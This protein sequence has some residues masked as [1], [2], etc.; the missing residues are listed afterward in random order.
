MYLEGESYLDFALKSIKNTFEFV[1]NLLNGYLIANIILQTLFIHIPFLVVLV[2]GDMLAGEAT[3]GTYRLM[4]TRPVSRTSIITAKFI[5]GLVYTNL[6][7]VCLMVFSLFGSILI[8]G[9]GELLV[10]QDK[11]YIFAD[12]DVMWRFWMS[13]GFAS[14]SLSVVFALSFLFSALVENAIGP[15]IATMAV[16]IVFLII[17]ILNFE[18]LNAIKPYLFV[19]HMVKWREFMRDPV[20]YANIINSGLVLMAHIIIFFAATVIIFNKKD[21]LT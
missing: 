5:S 19:T 10:V 16:I 1:G 14:L 15:I 7:I 11:V 20:N 6:L 9:T 12:D 18:L 8:F 13:Y 4:L 21:V 2:G 17:T 3:A